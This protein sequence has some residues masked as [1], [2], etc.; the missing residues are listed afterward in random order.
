MAAGYTQAQ[1][2]AEARRRGYRISPKLIERWVTLGLIDQ[3]DAT[4]R[5]RGKGVERRWP[6]HQRQLFLRLL[7]QHQHAHTMRSLTNVPVLVWLLWGE[8]WV[9]LRQVRRC[10]ETYCQATR[11]PRTFRGTAWAATLVRR[12]ARPG[13]RG[14]DRELLADELLTL[15]RTGELHETDLRHLLTE[16]V[17]PDDPAAQLDGRRAYEIVLAQWRL[18]THFYELTD[19]HYGWARAWYLYGQADYATAH[20][21]LAADPR[22]GGLHEPFDFQHVANS[23]AENLRF[24]LALALD[25]EGQDGGLPE[26]LRLETWLAGRAHLRTDVNVHVSPL[27]LPAGVPNAGLAIAVH[28]DVDPA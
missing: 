9:P 21:E 12:L 22:F 23:A 20:K 16:V 11:D 18:L 26:A 19:A 17:G 28:I 25:P 4:G 1:L 2:V 13:T 8:D 6:E 24:I 27:I 5:G 10:M 7:D 14:R 3:A 15:V